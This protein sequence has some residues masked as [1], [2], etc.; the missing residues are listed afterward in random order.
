MPDRSRLILLVAVFLASFILAPAVMRGPAHS[1]SF[2]G[3]LLGVSGTLFMLPTLIYPY[4]KHIL[5]KRGKENPLDSHIYF[6]LA[7]P[8][9]IALHVGDG[10]IAGTIPTL[11]FFLMLAVVASGFVGAFLFQRVNRSLKTQKGD[12]FTLKRFFQSRRKEL[13]SCRSYPG[14]EKVLDGGGKNGGREL[15]QDSDVSAGSCGALL[16]LAQ[17]IAELEYSTRAFSRL[18]DLFSYW[19]LVHAYTG[20]FLF[21]MIVVHIITSLYFGIRWLQ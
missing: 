16:V 18:K 15:D 13:L 8:I 7:G 12:L 1:G 4:R 21:M 11:T 10:F 3:H 9:L 14:I 2:P 5:G 20:L 17:A 19:I 6:G